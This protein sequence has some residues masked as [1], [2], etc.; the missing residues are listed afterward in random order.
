M[1][2]KIISSLLAAV[3]V[4]S[5]AACGSG[6][7]QTA[8]TTANNQAAAEKTEEASET[9]KTNSD[10]KRDPVTL[11][12]SWWGGDERHEATLKTIEQFEAKYPWITVEAEY[13]SYDGYAEKKMT[14][15]ASGT[16]PDIFQIE[17]GLGPEY[18]E[19]GV[20]YNLSDT[21]IDW[22]KFDSN[23]LV[24]NGQFGSGSQYAIPTGQAG[25][26]IIVNKTLAD[27]IG[28]DFTEQYT[29]DKLIE[30]GKQVQEYDPELYLIS[31][32]TSY[33]T[34][35]T[36]R[37]WCRQMNGKPIIDS[38]LNLTMTQEQFEQCFTYIKELYDN[39]VCAP[40]AYKAPFG[41]QDQGDPNWIA[42]KYV[43]SVGYTSSAD[44]LQAANPEVEYIAGHMPVMENAV[45]DGWFNDTPQFIGMYAKTKHPEGAALF[46][47]YFF[48]DEEAAK[49]LGTVRS[50]PPTKSAQEICEKAGTLN[51]LTKMSVE[52]SMLYNG[53]SD[54]GKTT[55]SEVTSILQDA[56]ENISF[57]AKSP[58]DNAAEVVAMLN[59]YISSQK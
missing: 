6:E 25:T 15:F 58:A 17:T 35:F 52:V 57:G 16:A 13:S 27:Q 38:D 3:M 44:I 20:L 4:S 28:I 49:T 33:M 48:N 24:N 5:L 36:L 2:K 19:Q 9:S 26:A 39:N 43:S 12:F 14:E 22:S 21:A 1:K 55:G 8:S 7:T 29:W 11:R 37:A 53:E 34:A 30:W 32:N 59:D 54:G 18:Y 42:G 41:D 46:L 56:Y 51:P 23:F 50:V 31:G 47:D 40:A 45:S 10:E